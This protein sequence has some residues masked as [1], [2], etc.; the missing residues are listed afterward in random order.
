MRAGITH[1]YF[2]SIHPFED[3]NGRIARAL[4]EKHADR[5][6]QARQSEAFARYVH[7]CLF[8]D[9]CLSVLPAGQRT[10]LWRPS[11][12][13]RRDGIPVDRRPT[14]CGGMTALM[15]LASSHA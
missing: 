9:D 3:G 6:G 11:Y 8:C 7:P 14:A 12:L 2:I 13:K 1:H 5:I 10:R 4:V 15:S